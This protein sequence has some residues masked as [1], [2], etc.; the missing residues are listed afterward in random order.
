LV[1]VL[2]NYPQWLVT[3][4][5]QVLKIWEGGLSWHGALLGG[6]LAGWTYARK[7]GVNPNLIADWSVLGLSFGYIIVRIGNIFNQ[8]VLGRVTEFTFGRW[9]AQLVG[10]LIGLILLIR[11]LYLQRKEVPTGYQF[12]S[13]IGYHQV[14]RALFEEPV[15]EN[16][17]FLLKYVHPRWGLGF[18]TLTQLITPLV[19]AFA[20]YMYRT[21][22]GNQMRYGQRT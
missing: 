5:V 22:R 20:Y 21:T 10:S 1:F 14:L 4:P 13:F 17:L 2:A 19:L 8:E 3:E 18:F 7:N 16:A 15:R 12:W 11:F 9:P 6:F